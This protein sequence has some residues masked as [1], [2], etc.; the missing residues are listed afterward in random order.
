MAVLCIED[1]PDILDNL[2]EMLEMEGYH[3][4]P[5]SNGKVG[6][7]IAILEVPDFIICNMRMPYL[8]GYQV[9]RIIRT[10]SITRRIPFMFLSTNTMRSSILRA[11]L[12]GA[13]YYLTKPYSMTEL[14]SILRRHERLVCQD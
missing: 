11:I 1:C 14:I 12:L 9:L 13:N 10:F 6:V 3:A 4:I 5:A 7:Q 8:D 2:C